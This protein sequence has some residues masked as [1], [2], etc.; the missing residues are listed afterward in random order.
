MQK[1]PSAA[2]K[3]DRVFINVFPLI[4]AIVLF[5][6][7]LVLVK[8][9]KLINVDKGMSICNTMVGV[10]TTC[11]GFMITAVSVLLALNS[12]DYIEMLKKTGHYKTILICF[13]SC[14]LHILVILSIMVAITITQIWTVLIFAIIC[15]TTIDALLIIGIC[16]WFLLTIVIKIND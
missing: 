14:C 11:L 2:V 9:N 12:S 8:E 16:L 10:W 5:S 13:V 6:V 7:I 3:R 4:I 1:K 15:A